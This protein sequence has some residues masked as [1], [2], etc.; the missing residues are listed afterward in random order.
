MSY[1]V[2]VEKPVGVAIG[3]IGLSRT[4]LIRLLAALHDEL[5][6]N[7][8]RHRQRRSPNDPD[9]FIFRHTVADGGYWYTCEF[10]VNDVKANGY[11][12]VEALRYR[13]DPIPP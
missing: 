9:L 12:F 5:T 10:A 11:L 13:S 1:R 2:V 6:N 7:A 4:G 3:F 8:A